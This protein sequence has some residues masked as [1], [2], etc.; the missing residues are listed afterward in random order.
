MLAV[1]SSADSARDN[2]TRKVYVGRGRGANASGL[3]ARQ[4]S[5]CLLLYYLRDKS[6]S[7][8]AQEREQGHAAARPGNGRAH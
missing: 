4:A 5:D 2:A 6:K 3:P 1:S 7:L 8:R